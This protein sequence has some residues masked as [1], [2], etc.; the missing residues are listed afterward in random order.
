MNDFVEA[1]RRGL[2]EI[3]EFG[4]QVIR[5]KVAEHPGLSVRFTFRGKVGREVGRDDDS[6]CEEICV[7]S[8]DDDGRWFY[9]WA[10]ILNEHRNAE[11]IEGQIEDGIE[12][13]LS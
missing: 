7:V 3:N 12:E 11:R 13:F 5:L 2:V 8:R 6:A 10:S 4:R 1:S 9:T